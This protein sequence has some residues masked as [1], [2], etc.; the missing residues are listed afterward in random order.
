MF[1]LTI[2]VSL[3]QFDVAKFTE[4]LKE[5]IRQRMRVAA[6]A[7]VRAALLRVPVQSGMARGSFLN[8]GRLL[9]VAIPISPTHTGEFSYE[10]GGKQL[11][12]AELGASLATPAEQMFTENGQSFSFKFEPGV[13]HYAI[14]EF[15]GRIPNA[16][17]LSLEQG[18]AAFLEEM[19]NLPK[20]VPKI[21]DY[22]IKQTLQ[23][24]PGGVKI[25][26][27]EYPSGN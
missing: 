8:I 14:N 22:L 3:L 21:K 11:K 7:F 10:Y 24:G 13:I 26:S 2:E 4:K 6:R 12:T 18:R 25:I 27:T 9:R 17:W 16:P 5:V 1:D 23:G 15:Y 19:G 20:F